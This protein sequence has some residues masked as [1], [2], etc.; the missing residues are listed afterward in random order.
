MR[1]NNKKAI[2]TTIAIAIIVALV[3]GLA[4]GYLVSIFIAPPVLRKITETLTKTETTR[5]TTT[6]TQAVIK[7][8]TVVG[9]GA[10]I[11]KTITTTIV[12][13]IP[14]VPDPG[15]PPEAVTPASKYYI[16]GGPDPEHN[17]KGVDAFSQISI[18]NPLPTWGPTYLI[19]M[20]HTKDF[21]MFHIINYKHKATILEVVELCLSNP[22]TPSVGTPVDVYV[23]SGTGMPTV[24]HDKDIALDPAWLLIGEVTILPPGDW[25][26]YKLNV[27]GTVI[28]KLGP[29]SEFYITIRLVEGEIGPDPGKDRNVN[30]AWIKIY[31]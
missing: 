3:L 2:I 31:A 1:K 15:P 18:P 27:P 29:R 30:I 13:L 20:W 9:S 7:T 4:L 25:K 26:V 8:E 5:A 6:I 16:T 14:T 17:Y 11:T 10:I 24:S 19:S 21:V 28:Q 12:P 23:W 22:Q